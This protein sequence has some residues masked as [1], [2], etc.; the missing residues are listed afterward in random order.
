MLT[1]NVRL[2]TGRKLSPTSSM[3]L[4]PH[5]SAMKCVPEANQYKN[6]ESESGVKKSPVLP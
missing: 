2:C 1:V 5:S 3:V 4:T 6:D